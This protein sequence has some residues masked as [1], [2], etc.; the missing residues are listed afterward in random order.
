MMAR[1]NH[2]GGKF[3][4]K[5]GTN[6]KIDRAYDRRSVDYGRMVEDMKDSSGYH[7]PGSRKKIH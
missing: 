4:D 2:G 3:A 1:E 5:H 7:K 6:R